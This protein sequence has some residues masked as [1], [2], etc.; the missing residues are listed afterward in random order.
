MAK[1]ALYL[2]GV[3]LTLALTGACKKQISQAHEYPSSP[4][5]KIQITCDSSHVALCM[6]RLANLKETRSPE[7]EQERERMLSHVCEGKKA[8]G[9]LYLAKIHENKKSPGALKWY[10]KAC[11]LKSR[12]GCYNAGALYLRGGIIP[13][14]L[15]KGRAFLEKSCLLGDAKGCFNAGAMFAEGEGGPKMGE[16]A[17]TLYTLG[18]RKKSPSACF[19][20]AVMYDQGEGGPQDKPA[21][22]A[23]LKQACA[24]KIAP[25]CYNLGVM[26]GKG[27]A[28]QKSQ[29]AAL[30]WFIKACEA[31]N[32]KGCYDAAVMLS[33]GDGVSR[34]D[35]KSQN[36]FEKAC[37]RKHG[38]ACLG[39]AISLGSSKTSHNKRVKALST[40]CTLKLKE[41]CR[42]LI[43]EHLNAQEYKRALAILQRLC[44]EH[45][46][47]RE[48]R[49][50]IHL[51]KS[52]KAGTFDEGAINLWYN[53]LCYCGETWRCIVRAKRYARGKGVEK[54]HTLA[55][56]LFRRACDQGHARTCLSLAIIAEHASPPKLNEAKLLLKKACDLKMKNGCDHLQRLTRKSTANRP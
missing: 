7:E 49:R 37:A 22:V 19:N 33:T 27:E 3:G 48:C 46:D 44:K 11:R 43:T 15:V 34:D 40:A 36:L 39:L 47:K 29:G 21:A 32:T 18:C 12:E 10:S 42:L 6:E 41:A 38:A 2:A 50:T 56:T 20:L 35:E 1:T 54:N 24:G 51:M 55:A 17:R 5:P 23:A 53:E 26:S 28:T 13:K 9:C 31:G 30:A 52:G 14:N 4:T 16:R 8:L 25:A 45:D